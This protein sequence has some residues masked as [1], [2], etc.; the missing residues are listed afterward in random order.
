MEKKEYQKPEMQVIEMDT[1]TPL[2]AGSG[3]DSFEDIIDDVIPT[4]GGRD[5]ACQHGNGNKW[6]CP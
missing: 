6:F 5:N 3:D 4:G 1:K 2:L